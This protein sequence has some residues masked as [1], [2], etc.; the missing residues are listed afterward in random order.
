MFVYL[1]LFIFVMSQARAL[2]NEEMSSSSRSYLATAMSQEREA[3]R[4]KILDLTAH[5]ERERADHRGKLRQMK[6][7]LDIKVR[8]T[9]LYYINTNV[10][11]A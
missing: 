4:E 8:G 2:R 1:C 11:Y 6:Q 9:I 10:L 7:K 5:V 3:L